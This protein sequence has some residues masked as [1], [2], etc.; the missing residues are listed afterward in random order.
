MKKSRFLYL[1]SEANA[2]KVAALEA[3]QVAYTGYLQV[4]TDALLDAHRFGVSLGEM[5]TFFA[6]CAAFSSQIVKNVRQHAI[7]IVSGWAASKYATTLRA[8]I[9]GLFKAVEI[10]AAMRSALCI[11]G[12][13]SVDK[14]GGL[15]TQAALDLYWKLLL[16]EDVAGKRSAI[17]DRCGMRMSEMT[18]VLDTSE[19]TA[20]TGWWLG[21]S[22]LAIGAPR[23]Q[24]PLVSNPYVTSV[25]EVSKGILARKDKRGRWRFEVVDR[26]AWEAPA[27]EPGMPRVGVDVGLNVVAAT[28]DGRL[29]GRELKPRFDRLHAQVQR[30]RSNRYRQDLKKN[31][32]RLDAMEARLTGM[33]K[34]MTGEVAN[35][36]VRS[37]PGH[38]FVIEDLD[39]RGCRGSKRMA[40]RALHRNLETK[41]PCLV[42]NPAYTSQACPSCGHVSRRN[43]RG[44]AFACINCGRRSHADVVGGINL[45]RRSED[46]QIGLDDDPADVR[47]ILRERALRRRRRCTGD[48]SAG[49]RTHEPAP[50]GQRLTVGGSREDVRTA[51][52]QVPAVAVMATAGS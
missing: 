28:S 19:E 8:H 15:V 30:V 33:V 51:S 52:N 13:R 29:L 22:Y 46:K 4:C 18:A 38:A 40:Y 36:L 9:K 2:G 49:G 42:V 41:A 12:K 7:A 34:T 50:S 31:S 10:D 1:H 16:D 25:N 26:R 20:I 5:Q 3:L 24:V 32:P 21:F 35:E 48:S 27:A 23:I 43:R 17:S 14:P 11:I 37:Y 45:L 6:P 44:T 39:L 47:P